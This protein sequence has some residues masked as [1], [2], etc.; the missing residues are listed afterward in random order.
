MTCTRHQGFILAVAALA[1][2]ACA[3][4]PPQTALESA[5]ADHDSCTSQGYEFP[6]SRYVGC[7]YRLAEFRHQRAWQNLDMMRPIRI[8]QG[9]ESLH[10]NAY[11][12]LSRERFRCVAR[13]TTDGVR[14]IYC[15][16]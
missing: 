15:D 4:T 7:R 2:S 8:D 6:S 10:M 9:P 11:R 5:Q 12:P 16:T 1:V 3:S 14:W 13:E